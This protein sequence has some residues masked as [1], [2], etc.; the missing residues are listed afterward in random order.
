MYIK[1]LRDFTVLALGF[2]ATTHINIFAARCDL[3]T[4]PALEIIY[5]VEIGRYT[6]TLPK[7]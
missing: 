2:V 5:V 3:A 6:R 1:G 4:I 7:V